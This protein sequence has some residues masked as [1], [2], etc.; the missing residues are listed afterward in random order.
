[1]TELRKTGAEA[2]KNGSAILE[3]V[4]KEDTGDWEGENK[5]ISKFSATKIP[6]FPKKLSPL[7]L[8]SGLEGKNVIEEPQRSNPT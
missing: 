2:L 5:F 3:E 8:I 6:Q 4:G 7:P 1:M